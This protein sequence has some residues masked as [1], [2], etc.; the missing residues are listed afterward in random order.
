MRFLRLHSNTAVQKVTYSCHPGHRLGQ[1][2]RDVKFLADTKKQSYLGALKDCVVRRRCLI[3]YLLGTSVCSVFSAT[4][5]P[6]KLLLMP[7]VVFYWTIFEFWAP[8]FTLL[9]RFNSVLFKS[10]K[11]LRNSQPYNLVA[12]GIHSQHHSLE[13]PLCNV[14]LFERWEMLD[15]LDW[16]GTFRSWK[17]KILASMH[18]TLQCLLNSVLLYSSGLP[19]FILV[20]AFWELL[21]PLLLYFCGHFALFSSM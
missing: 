17:N 19:F 18:C 11:E 20:L 9:E 13:V 2:D 14:I 5:R 10:P 6:G 15:H 3:L 8:H 1:S 4:Q 12:L 21:F 16:M 7:S